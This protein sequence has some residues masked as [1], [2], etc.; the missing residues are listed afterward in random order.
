MTS[1]IDV[2]QAIN[3][4]IVLIDYLYLGSNNFVVADNSL[5][6]N[7][8]KS[9]DPQMYLPLMHNEPLLQTVQ[10]VQNVH[11][12]PLLQTL[13]HSEPVMQDTAKLQLIDSPI[14]C[15]VFT[16]FFSSSL[17]SDLKIKAEK[18]TLEIFILSFALFCYFSA[19]ILIL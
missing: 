4:L 19:C 5:P 16:I 6:A 17:F 15:Q 1:L 14:L 13:H 3:G 9:L 12:E 2:I 18:D 10:T 8:E 11:N 7:M